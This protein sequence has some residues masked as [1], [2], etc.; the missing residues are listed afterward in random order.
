MTLEVCTQTSEGFTTAALPAKV[1]ENS[2]SILSLSNN[3][4]QSFSL[5]MFVHFFP[6]T[7]NMKC[8]NVVIDL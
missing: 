5:M 3:Y 7:F 4:F 1:E 6:D 8:A 2:S